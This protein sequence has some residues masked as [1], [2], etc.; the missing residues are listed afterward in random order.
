MTS[1]QREVRALAKERGLDPDHITYKATEIKNTG[2][3]R[4][5]ISF[6]LRGQ[7]ATLEDFVKAVEESPNFLIVDQI[8]LQEGTDKDLLLTVDLATYFQSPDAVALA[9]AFQR[10]GRS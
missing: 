4:F 9:R 1:I 3:V 10:A 5:Q 8:Q 2:L 7:Y 6:P